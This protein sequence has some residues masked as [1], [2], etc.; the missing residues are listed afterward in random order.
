MEKFF[1]VERGNGKFLASA[2]R[3]PSVLLVR[4][5]L[6]LFPNFSQT[7][8]TLYLM[9]HCTDLSFN[10][11]FLVEHNRETNVTIA[12]FPKILLGQF[13]QIFYILIF[14]NILVL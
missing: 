5:A 14:R 11:N 6:Q 10:L 8:K 9:I 7:L 1:L 3:L 13:L 2:W 12:K 4:K